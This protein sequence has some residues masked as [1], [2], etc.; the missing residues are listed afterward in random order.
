M[1]NRSNDIFSSLKKVYDFALEHGANVLALT[2]PECAAQ[3]P[4]LDSRREELN[5]L[6]TQYQPEGFEKRL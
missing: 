4:N 2:V 3:I 5:R 6:I 1:G